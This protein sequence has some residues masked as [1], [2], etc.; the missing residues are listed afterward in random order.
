MPVAGRDGDLIQKVAH[1]AMHR[2]RHVV[3]FDWESGVEPSEKDH[4][5]EKFG[6]LGEVT[7]KMHRHSAQWTRPAGFER[8]TW[9]FDTSLGD[10]AA[11]GLVAR[12]HGTRRGEGDALRRDR[13]R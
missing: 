12:R 8:L 5:T 7:A 4:L 10:D 3:L 6:I 1:P 13:R 11:L 2:P 9:D